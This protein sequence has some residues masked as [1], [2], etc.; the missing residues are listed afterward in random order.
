ML[1]LVSKFLASF[2]VG[3]HFQL[4]ALLFEECSEALL[5]GMDNQLKS[6]EEECVAHLQLIEDLKKQFSDANISAHQQTLY[7]LQVNLRGFKNRKR[8]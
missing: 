1:L 6:L 2:R 5:S 7:D 8:Q 4:F 3:E